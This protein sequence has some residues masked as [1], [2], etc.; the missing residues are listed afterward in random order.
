MEDRYSALIQK[1]LPK[2]SKDLG[3]FNLPVTKFFIYGQGL[4]GFRGKRQ[5]NAFD[6]SKEDRKFGGLTHQDIAT[7]DRQIHQIS[8][9]VV[10]DV[11]VKVENFIFPMDLL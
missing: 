4:T 10:E 3:S 1:G 9:D 7:V 6:N 11:L 2:K 5:F 8:Y